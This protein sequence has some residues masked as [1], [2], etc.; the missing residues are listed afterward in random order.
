MIEMERDR[1]DRQLRTV[2][3]LILAVVAVGAAMHFLRPVLVPFFLALF[4]TYCLTP[5]IDFQVNALRMPRLLAIF[6]AA[7]LGLAILALCGL[8]VAASV[9]EIA[10][11]FDAYQ[12]YFKQFVE[13]TAHSMHLERVGIHP[14]PE[15]GRYLTIPDDAIKDLLSSALVQVRDL[16]S[17]GILVVVFMIFILLGRRSDHP[18]TAGL[19]EDIEQS[20]RRYTLLMVALSALTGLL[21]GLTLALL[22]VRFAFLFGFLAFLLN[23][24]PNVGS[25]VATLLPVPVILLSPDLS[26]TAKVLAL[27][28]PAAFQIALGA[29]VQPKALG[30]SLDLHPVVVL[31]ALVFFGMIWGVSG[32]FLAAPITAVIKIILERIPTTRPLAALLA[33]D[34]EVFSRRATMANHQEPPIAKSFSE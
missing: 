30:S 11:N 33:G 34:L 6:G 5:V 23:F 12:Q 15:T 24:I 31:M 7:L 32:A 1:A 21:V 17:G 22:D 16:V 14:D 18:R 28:L 27:T 25:V 13:S 2:C 26:F 20:V 3:L 8:V 9:G 29:V 10:E 4:F 19:L